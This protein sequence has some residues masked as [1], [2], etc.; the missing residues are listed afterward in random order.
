MSDIESESQWT[1]K[2]FMTR[3]DEIM[4][5]QKDNP[6]FRYSHGYYKAEQ[7]H[8]DKFGK[9]RFKTYESFREYRRQVLFPK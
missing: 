8:I 1:A 6:D 4:T 9:S 5:E 7:E 3:F 2:G